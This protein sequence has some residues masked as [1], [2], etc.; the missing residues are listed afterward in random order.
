[1]EVLASGGEVLGGEGEVDG[2]EGVALL[3]KGEERFE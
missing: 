2:V 3:G 1:V